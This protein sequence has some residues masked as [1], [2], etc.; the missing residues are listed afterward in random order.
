VSSPALFAAAVSDFVCSRD[1]VGPF[2]VDFAT[3]AA[4]P[5]AGVSSPALFAAAVSAFLCSRDT[6]ADACAAADCQV[7]VAAMAIVAMRTGLRDILVPRD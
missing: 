5:P 4:P 3:G 2:A 7:N 6:G 1:F